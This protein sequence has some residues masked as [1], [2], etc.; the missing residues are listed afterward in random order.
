MEIHVI[1]RITDEFA[2]AAARLVPQL[3]P[4]AAVPDRKRLEAVAASSTSLLLAAER[5]GLTVGMLTLAWYETPT[6][7]RAWIE[8]VVVDAAARGC[9]VGRALVREALVRA[10]AL[11]VTSLMLTSAPARVAARR[12]YSEEGFEMAETSVFRLKEMKI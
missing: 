9:G 2:L 11:G 6:G 10:A 5:E 12:L 7:R 1:K 4:R 8:D 3:S